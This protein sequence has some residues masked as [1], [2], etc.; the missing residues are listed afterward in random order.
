MSTKSNDTSFFLDFEL[1]PLLHL[2]LDR[3][4][5]FLFPTL[6]AHSPPHSEM[7][8]RGND[9][10]NMILFHESIFHFYLDFLAW[11]CSVVIIDYHDTYVSLFVCLRKL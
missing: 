2:F 3:P 8:L 6:F 10:N 9:L 11:K 5:S 1:N 4:F 7:E